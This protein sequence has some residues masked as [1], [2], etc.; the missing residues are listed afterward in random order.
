MHG[1][2]GF[3]E[4]TVHGHCKQLIY[5]FLLHQISGVETPCFSYVDET[6]LLFLF[7]LIP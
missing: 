7:A 4:L 1:Y 2:V 6:P 3:C 5:K